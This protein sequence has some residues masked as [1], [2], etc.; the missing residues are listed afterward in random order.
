MIPAYAVSNAAGTSFAVLNTT[1]NPVD[2]HQNCTN[3]DCILMSSDGALNNDN[4]GVFVKLANCYSPSAG[5][6][7]GEFVSLSAV[8]TSTRIS[9]L[10]FGKGTP[11]SLCTTPNT[12]HIFRTTATT[13][14][15]IWAVKLNGSNFPATLDATNFIQCDPAGNFNTTTGCDPL[16]PVTHAVSAPIDLI[17]S[18]KLQ[19]FSKEVG[20]K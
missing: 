12:W 13:P 4:Q 17:S 19:T 7:G 11:S 9:T 15:T 3:L 8:M 18:G 20:L 2:G 5:L 10:T 6:N 14:N 16:A 1:K